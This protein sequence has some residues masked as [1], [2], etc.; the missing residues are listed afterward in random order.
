MPIEVDACIAG[1]ARLAKRVETATAEIAMEG[2]FLVE[3]AAKGDAPVLTGT[4][5]RSIDVKGPHMLGPFAFS[6]DVGPTVVYGRMRELG[7][8]I[9]GGAV[10][11]PKPPGTSLYWVDS[12]GGQHF[13]SL[14]H[15]HGRPYLRPALVA[16][17]EKYHDLAARRWNEALSGLGGAA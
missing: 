2:A 1:L 5:R 14:V 8:W 13:A 6:A 9:P 4:L 11:R 15:Q 16:S 7:G 10:P 17:V 3:A 12:S